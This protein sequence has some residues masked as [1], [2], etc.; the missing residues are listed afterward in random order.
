MFVGHYGPSFAAKVLQPSIPLWVFFLAVQL[1]DVLWAIL[2]I[3]GIEEVRI[4]PGI[5]ASNPLDL[6]HVPYT[7]SLVAAMVWTAV[8]VVVARA[9]PGPHSWS[10]GAV[11]GA[12]VL[13]HWF[14]DLVVHRPDLPLYGDAFK[15]G[16]GLWDFPIVAM[17]LELGSAFAGLVVYAR[18]TQPHNLRGRSSILGFGSIILLAQGLAFVGPPPASGS[19]AAVTALVAYGVFAAAAYWLESV[20]L[21]RVP[22]GRTA[23]GR[24]PRSGRP[25]RTA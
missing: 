25:R 9:L 23:A 3:L 12:A 15:V 1:V 14:L 17:T 19:A 24:L 22:G 2:V 13:S 10:A 6:H 5:T 4:V 7:H 11:V 8:T 21:Q 16:L 18:R 20:G